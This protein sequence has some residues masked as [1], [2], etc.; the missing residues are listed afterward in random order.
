MMNLHCGVFAQKNKPKG[1]LEE[2]VKDLTTD[3]NMHVKN[4]ME[5]AA[6]RGYHLKKDEPT[7]EP[8][9]VRISR[10]VCTGN[11]RQVCTGMHGRCGVHRYAWQVCTGMH[12][13]EGNVL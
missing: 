6:Y 12:G 5:L 4:S 10:Q 13:S 3:K 2:L 9:Q 1:P 7:Q 11:A 8:S